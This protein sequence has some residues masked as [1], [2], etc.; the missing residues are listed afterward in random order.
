MLKVLVGFVSL[1]VTANVYATVQIHVGEAQIPPVPGP[2]EAPMD[3][4]L[5]DDLVPVDDR[6]NRYQVKLRLSAPAPTESALR[7]R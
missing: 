6:I 2:R 5:S 1:A 4:Y 7:C 3:V